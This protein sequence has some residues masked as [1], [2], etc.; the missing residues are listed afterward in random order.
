MLIVHRTIMNE[1][2]KPHIDRVEHTYVPQCVRGEH[3]G[4]PE[5]G[6]A[7]Q[8]GQNKVRLTKAKQMRTYSEKISLEYGLQKNR[9]QRRTKGTCQRNT[10]ESF[11]DY[12]Q[13][14]TNKALNL[15]GG[16]CLEISQ[17]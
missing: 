3:S 5:A 13:K 14:D 8:T 15:R 4:K 2:V 16:Y 10:V 17:G 7:C 6:V 12:P 9:N 11:Q 1:K